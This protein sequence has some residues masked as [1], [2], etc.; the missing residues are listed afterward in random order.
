MTMSW[1]LR[2]ISALDG[3]EAILVDAGVVDADAVGGQSH[4]DHVG[5]HRGADR[6]H[7]RGVAAC[8]AD[9][10][11]GGGCVAPDVDVGA[12]RLDRDGDAVAL[13]ERDRGRAVGEEERGVDD[14]EREVFADRV[15]DGDE[16]ALQRCGVVAA[17]EE[18]ADGEA[19]A[20]EVDA[21][22]AFVRRE[23]GE[24]RVV[25]EVAE[26]AWREAYRCYRLQ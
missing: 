17:L 20:V 16:R 26:R 11:G 24:G 19:R 3:V 1:P 2:G 22:P 7:A 6:E 23:R 8:G 9:L 12:A 14:V 10:C 21:F 15:E 5:L 25:A 18:R 4:R 13:A